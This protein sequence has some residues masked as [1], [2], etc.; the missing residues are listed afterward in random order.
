MSYYFSDAF[1]KNKKSKRWTDEFSLKFVVE[2]SSWFFATEI[3]KLAECQSVIGAAH[4]NDS[5]CWRVWRMHRRYVPNASNPRRSILAS[6]RS[7][8]SKSCV[9]SIRSGSRV[10]L[11]V[12]CCSVCVHVDVDRLMMIQGIISNVRSF[13]LSGRR[14]LDSALTYNNH[15]K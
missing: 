7:I 11:S 6:L 1:L 14:V 9:L 4:L 3:A 15:N 5:R 2:F 13:S 8:K 10:L 12:V